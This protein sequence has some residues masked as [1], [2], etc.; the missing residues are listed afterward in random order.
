MG[1]L[2]SGK[3]V[4]SFWRDIGRATR[5]GQKQ[6]ITKA[7]QLVHKAV[8]EELDGGN[9]GRGRAYRVGRGRRRRRVHKASRPGDAPATNT[10]N[11]RRAVAFEINDRGRHPSARVGVKS[12]AGYARHLDPEPGQ[13]EPRI[14]RRPFL[15]SAVKNTRRDVEDTIRKELEKALRRVM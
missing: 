1:K 3:D 9:P 7:A 11:L 2:V 12:T 13:R 8:L 15:S 14:G 5:E 4:A 10:G 6:A